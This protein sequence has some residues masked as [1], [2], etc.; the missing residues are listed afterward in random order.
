MLLCLE[1][2]IISGYLSNEVPGL[3]SGVLQLAGQKE[4]LQIELQG[5][6]LRDIAGCRIELSNPCPE[7]NP[8]DA[9]ALV[10]WQRGSVGVMTA[11]YRVP[12]MPRKRRTNNPLIREPAGLKNM[13]FLEW[14]TEQGQR[15]LVQSWH[16]RLVVS[17]PI[18][19]QSPQEELAQMKRNRSLRKEFL[20]GQKQTQEPQ[21]N[22]A[23][24]TNANF[25]SAATSSL[26]LIDHASQELTLELRRFQQ[27]LASPSDLL[28]RPAVLKL[29]NTAGDLA[30]HLSHVLRNFRT[31]RSDEWAMLLTDLEQSHP[32]FHAALTAC[33]KLMDQ[34][35]PGTDQRWLLGIQRC[36]T[37]ITGQ[38]EA[39]MKWLGRA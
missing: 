1:S 2:T 26:P 31:L 10:P 6:F 21:G 23:S 35:T 12:M 11:S 15:V 28:S 36:L 39:L 27:L 8:A 20:L 33:D 37:G 25:A 13:L 17:A 9:A 14:F 30:A 29:L 19:R 24:S 3:V 34:S 18:W 5:N 38:L 16:I 32:F 7:A 4:P 22:W